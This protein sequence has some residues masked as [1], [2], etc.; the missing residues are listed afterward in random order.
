[1]PDLRKN[2]QTKPPQISLL[3]VL[4][5]DNRLD[6]DKARQNVGPDLDP[7]SIPE[8]TFRKKKKM[9][10]KQISIKNSAIVQ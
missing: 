7:N 2:I 5:A 6:P 8:R 3:L 10:L 9:I 4:S 1:M